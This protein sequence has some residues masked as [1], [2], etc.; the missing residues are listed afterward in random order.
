MIDIY[1]T[2]KLCRFFLIFRFEDT[3]IHLRITN[4]QKLQKWE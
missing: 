4:E 2:K 1:I 3:G